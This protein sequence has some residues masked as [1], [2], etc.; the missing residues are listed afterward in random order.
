MS[1]KYYFFDVGVASALQGRRV[2]HGTAEFGA[3]FE[4]WL[5]HELICHR[6]YAS[7]ESIR[8]WRSTSGFEVD[9]ILDDH[10]AIEVKG[11]ENV[12]AHDLK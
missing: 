1:S 8:Y 3:A 2:S 10:T 11:K 4:T 7:G 12:S 6:D 5:L 9:F